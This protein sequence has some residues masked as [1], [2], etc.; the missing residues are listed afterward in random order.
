MQA[1][2]VLL[3]DDDPN[4]HVLTS[5]MLARA[6]QPFN[7]DWV[8]TY[9]EGLDVMLR[10]E[11][12]VYL[13]DYNLGDTSGLQ[14]LQEAKT[15]GLTKPIIMMTGNAK[16][17][18][19][20]DI[21][22]LQS[23]AT[24]Y[25][26]KVELRPV[27]L[28]RSIRYALERSQ[29]NY[30]LRESEELYR[31]L[32]AEAF[33]GIIITNKK[34]II[35][36]ANTRLCTMVGREDIDLI[37]QPF[38]DYIPSIDI[39]QLGDGLVVESQ[40]ITA[41]TS[42]PIEAEISAKPTPSGRVQ[43]IIRDITGRKASLAERDR[44]IEQLTILSQVDEE[45][46]QVFNLNFVLNIALDAAMRLCAA[47]SG[48]IGLLQEDGSIHVQQAFGAFGV[49]K[50]ED[51]LP[52]MPIFREVITESQARFIPDIE[53]EPLYHAVTAD[54]RACMLL[55][56][57][58]YEKLVGVMVMEARYATHFTQ[59][60]FE[61]IKLITTRIAV[62]I[63]HT[64]LYKTLQDRYDELQDLYSQVSALEQLKTDMIRIASHDIRNP[65]SVILG[66]VELMQSSPDKLPGKFTEYVNMIERSTHRLAKI[67]N[68]ILSL[69]QIENLKS[70]DYTPVDL[71]IIVQEMFEEFQPQAED[72]QISFTLEAIQ[73]D[74]FV[75]GMSAHL[76]EATANVI[77]NAIKYTPPNGKITVHLE[78]NLDIVTLRVVD[79]GYGIPD[80]KQGSLFQPFYR[81]RDRTT[82]NIEGTGLGLYLIK[83]IIERF[84]GE[85]IFS[86]TFGQGSTFG[87]RLPLVSAKG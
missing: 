52:K 76:R 45:I 57:Q 64:Q 40:L 24:D 81:V 75:S 11:H 19:G 4:Y 9:T 42:T 55:P 22:A 20:L 30:K 54:A 41:H 85:I 82:R 13:L 17:Q 7:V 87:F 34:G 29:V 25:I 77:S 84:G 70:G 79:T 38:T 68:D 60:T 53:A 26:D 59:D 51:Y 37:G 35:E 74:L 62:A 28:Q 50:P 1:I 8:G 71:G 3:V 27:T 16:G 23:G 49:Q 67:T 69:E 10:Q 32:I 47:T 65:V 6:D 2:K 43:F 5:R 86:S 61:F 78:S 12:D 58:S 48:F 33:D 73:E 31:S 83:N 44:H 46:N 72:K 80:D 36:L 63:E 14:L 66:Y 18:H 56:L 21:R 39:T 15:R